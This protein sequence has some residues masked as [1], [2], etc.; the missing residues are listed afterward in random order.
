M[1]IGLICFSF[2]PESFIRRHIIDLDATA[3]V[4]RVFAEQLQEGDAGLPFV[5]IEGDFIDNAKSFPMRALQY[6]QRRILGSGKIEMPPASKMKL[7]K[8]L[9][10]YKPDIILVEFGHLAVALL[11]LLK[12]LGIPVVPHFHGMDLSECWRLK[13]YRRQLKELLDYASAVVVVNERLQATRLRSIGCDSRKIHCIPC[14]ADTKAFW[15]DWE[16]A[17]RPVRF[18]SVARF[19]GQKGTLY[20]LRAFKECQRVHKDA[21]LLMIGDGPL[22]GKA[23]RYAARNG[24]LD[25]VRFAGTLSHKEVAE[26]M[27]AAS[28]L[29]QHSTISSKGDEEGWGVCMAEAAA[30]GLPV[31]STSHGGI[32]ELVLDDKTG[33]LVKERDWRAMAEKMKLLAEDVGLR[34][35]MGKTA[36][37][38]IECKGNASTQVKKLKKVLQ[39]VL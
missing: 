29:L 7:E 9:R 3:F 35:R 22:L 32:P 37:D 21:T 4:Q 18:I 30:C 10:K 28:V 19:V 31:V 39:S 27:R 6:M 13:G 24:L 25:A 16:K 8:E 2:P 23:K 36:R 20:S 17:G 26:E 5:S 15:P 33:F 11:P 38:R 12:E 14:G 34:I 1:R